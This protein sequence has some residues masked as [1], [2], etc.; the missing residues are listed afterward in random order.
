MVPPVSTIVLAITVSAAAAGVATLP[1]AGPA[2]AAGPRTV[3]FGHPPRLP[4]GAQAGASLPSSSA[5][6]VDVVL[7]PRDPAGLEMLAHD[8]TAPGSPLRGRFLEP[9]QFAARFGATQSAV[10]TV[11]RALRQRGLHPGRLS[12]DGLSIPVRAT[13]GAL[14]LAFGT[15]FRQYRL[16]DGHTVFAN[17]AA[18]LIPA[19]A[20]PDVQAVVGL[21]DVAVPVPA[22]SPA[23]DAP[24]TPQVP[25]APANSSAGPGRTRARAPWWWRRPAGLLDGL[26]QGGGRRGRDDRPGG[27]GLRLPEPL[28]GG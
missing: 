26:E 17:T 8:V 19:I 2:N 11:D 16:R 22:L 21:D 14:T 9:G 7:P 27:G 3:R 23:P 15:G 1:L 13:A 6:E 12:R 25:V 10:A 5:L 4:A 20:A 18:P 28:W 24:V